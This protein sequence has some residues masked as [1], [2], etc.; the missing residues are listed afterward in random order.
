ML[1]LKSISIRRKLPRLISMVPIL[2]TC[3]LAVMTLL[4]QS[5][6]GSAPTKTADPNELDDFIEN[7]LRQKPFVGISVA[8]LQGGR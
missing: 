5:F 2:V 7:Q 4:A 8:L 3:C 1:S 6:L